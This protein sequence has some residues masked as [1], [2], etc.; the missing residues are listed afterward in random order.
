MA[1]ADTIVRCRDG[2]VRASVVAALEAHG[3]PIERIETETRPLEELFVET[4]AA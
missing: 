4:V 1:G 2:A 3:V